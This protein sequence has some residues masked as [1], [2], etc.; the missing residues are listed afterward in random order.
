MV[1]DGSCLPSKKGRD[2]TKRVRKIKRLIRGW[3]I[4]NNIFNKKTNF[5]SKE[6]YRKKAAQFLKEGKRTE[7]EEC[8]QQCIDCTPQMALDVIQV[9]KKKN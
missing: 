9:T 8:F 6:A 4:K 7:A 5:R 1:F 3:L 2:E